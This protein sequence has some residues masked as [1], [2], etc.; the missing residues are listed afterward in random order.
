MIGEQEYLDRTSQLGAKKKNLS[1]GFVPLPSLL[2][3]FKN[4]AAVLFAV[5]RGSQTIKD[6]RL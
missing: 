2:W 5:R 4:A 3:S 1:E 6:A